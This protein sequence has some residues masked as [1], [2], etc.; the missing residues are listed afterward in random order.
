M[1]G[2]TSGIAAFVC[3]G[4]LVGAPLFAADEAG[5][6][7]RIGVLWLGLVE[8]WI[9]TF[10]ESLR[11]NGYTQGRTAIIDVRA[12]G[13]NLDLG[14]K[15]AE[16]IIALEPD[17]IY[18]VPAT[19]IN[20]VVDAQKKAGKQIP[21]VFLSADPVAEGLVTNA[22]HPGGKLTGVAATPNPDDLM[23]KHLQLLKE[24]NPRMRRVAC[25]I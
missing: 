11:E 20:D 15:L 12:V 14:P 25:L 16:E 21:I 6:L 17:V 22:A 19:L 10:H 9:K 5:R 4:M 1:I 3:M 23:T 7:P 2:K 24:M 8:P 13:Q 18:A